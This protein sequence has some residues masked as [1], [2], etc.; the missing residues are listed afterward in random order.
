MKRTAL[1]VVVLILAL[2]VSFAV[3][4]QDK[5]VVQIFFPISIDSPITEIL[6]GYA[7]AYMA[8]NPDVEIQW[9]FEGGYTDVKNRLL[10]VQ[11][12][13]G[14]LPALAIMLATDIYDLANAGAVQAWSGADDAYLADFTPTW[15]SNSYYDADG[16]GASELYGLPFQRSTVLMYYN[17]DLLEEAG[18]TAPANWEEL[19]TTAQALTTDS[20]EGIL[21]PNSWPYWVFQPFA[22]GAGQNIV[23]DSDVEVFFDTQASI[24]ALQYWTD[25]YQTYGATPDGVQDNWGDAPGAFTDGAAAMIVHSSGS[26]R[27]ILNTADFNVGVMGVPGKDGGSYSVTGGGNMYLVEGID[28]ATAAA[29]W[30]FVQWLTSPEQT[31]DWAIQSGYYNTRDSGFDLPAWQEYAAANPQVDQARAMLDSAVREFSVQSLADVRTAL[32]TE[33]LAVLNGETDP[34]SAMAE[35]QTQADDI[36]SIFQ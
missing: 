4:A 21:I 19:A 12:A 7:E 17:A 25:L 9:S 13:G 14:D 36:L 24:D 29:A 22:A 20:R 30:D 5:T 33:I 26:L 18:L 10:T 2:S 3:Q 27:N 28:E 35:A 23:S 31:V 16:D 32:H 1:L 8:E 15:L 6:N 34:A 11:E